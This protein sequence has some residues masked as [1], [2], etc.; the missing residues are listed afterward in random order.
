M[1]YIMYWEFNPED[2]DK[3]IKKAVKYRQMV[4][5]NPEKYPKN[6]FPSHS[7]GGQTKGIAILDATPEQCRKLVMHYLPEEKVKLV[8]LFEAA[9]FIEEYLKSK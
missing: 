1:K 6:L 7:L 9:L 2:M 5:K 3:V 4:E 8:P